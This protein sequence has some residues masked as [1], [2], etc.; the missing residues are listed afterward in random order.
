MSAIKES[1]IKN[2]LCL[3]QTAHT[4]CSVYFDEYMHDTNYYG[5]DYLT[6]D[7]DHLLDRLV[8]RQTTENFPYLSPGPKHIAYGMK[9]TD[10]NYPAEKWSMLNTDAHIRADLLGSNVTLGIKDGRLMNGSVGSIYFV[11]FDQTRE[12][13]RIVNIIL[14]GDDK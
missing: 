13:N 3:V 11:D 12:R 5:D 8:P 10:P 7:I 9:K 4:T 1:N 14:V 2:G 6:V